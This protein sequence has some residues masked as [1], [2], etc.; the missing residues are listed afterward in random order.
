[1]LS[2]DC[3]CRL[4]AAIQIKNGL[5]ISFYC[6][7]LLSGESKTPPVQAG[8]AQQQQARCLGAESRH[9]QANGR[10]LTSALP[11]GSKRMGESIQNHRGFLVNHSD[12]EGLKIK[13]TDDTFTLCHPSQKRYLLTFRPLRAGESVILAWKVQLPFGQGEI[14][15]GGFTCFAHPGLGATCPI[16]QFHCLSMPADCHRC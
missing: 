11:G 2:R 14:A 15:P 10:A 4:K 5:R 1:M 12:R 9:E 8:G 13:V 16:K 6:C 7:W 3:G